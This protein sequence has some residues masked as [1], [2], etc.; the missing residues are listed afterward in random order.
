M[1][2]NIYRIYENDNTIFYDLVDNIINWIFKKKIV[3]LL[4]SLF[5]QRND[6]KHKLKQFDSFMCSL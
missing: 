3:R 6:F 5:L 2:L 4:I 1:Q